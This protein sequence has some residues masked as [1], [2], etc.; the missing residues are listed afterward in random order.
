MPIKHAH[1]VTAGFNVHNVEQL[2][3]SLIPG[4]KFYPMG[5]GNAYL[6]NGL[7]TTVLA[8]A[9]KK[10]LNKL[11]ASGWRA[12]TVPKGGRT[13]GKWLVSQEGATENGKRILPKV[14][15]SD[16]ETTGVCTILLKTVTLKA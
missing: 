13:D 10:V 15:V 1:Q 6:T 7:V 8:P 5:V 11:K 3:T 4:L 2:V 9:A 16:P 14:F 12:A